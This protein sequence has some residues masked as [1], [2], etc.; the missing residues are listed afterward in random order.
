MSLLQILN[1]LKDSLNKSSINKEQFV[2]NLIDALTKANNLFSYLDDIQD[3]DDAVAL[4]SYQTA[5]GDR[6]L[7]TLVSQ[8]IFAYV[9]IAKDLSEAYRTHLKEMIA[10]YLQK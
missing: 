4:I 6:N 1:E 10:Y 5:G 7:A 8:L 9:N 3:F 2:T